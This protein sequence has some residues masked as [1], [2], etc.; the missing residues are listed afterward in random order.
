MKMTKKEKLDAI[1]KLLQKEALNRRQLATAIN[2]TI[3]SVDKYILEL[4]ANRLIYVDYYVRARRRP[5]PYWRAGNKLSAPRPYPRSKQE[6]MQ[7]HKLRKQTLQLQELSDRQQ[8]SFV[9]RRDIA[10]NWF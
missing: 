4:S 3:H 5:T 8:D 1:I 2:A 9:P 6:L 10:S 7:E